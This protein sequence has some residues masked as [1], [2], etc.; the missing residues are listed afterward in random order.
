ML[1]TLLVLV[2]RAALRASLEPRV[3]SRGASSPHKCVPMQIR[4]A[5]GWSPSRRL[6]LVGAGR[7]LFDHDSVTA[8][9]APVLHC[10]V[11]DEEASAEHSRRT[12]HLRASSQPQPS[13]DWVRL[14]HGM[15]SR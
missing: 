6:R 8:A 1:R 12:S 7:E 9:H 11:Q 5:K 4:K 13:F 2:W 15:Q 10:I 3:E 14:P